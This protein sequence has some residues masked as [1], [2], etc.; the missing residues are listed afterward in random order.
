MIYLT[1]SFVRLLGNILFWMGI[2][3]IVGYFWQGYRDGCWW[4]IGYIASLSLPISI[5]TIFVWFAFIP[6]LLAYSDEEFLIDTVFFGK[7]TLH[8]SD[9]KYYGYG[10]GMSVFM[11][12]FD[13]TRTFQISKL[14]YTKDQ[15]TAFVSFLETTFPDKKATGYIGD[16]MFK[17]RK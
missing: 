16:R 5:F 13:D 7:K 6:K 12:Q 8:W 2:L 9:L 15:W 14:A 3:I 11:L 17:W 1:R 4:T 10:R